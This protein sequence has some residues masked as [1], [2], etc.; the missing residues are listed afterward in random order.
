MNRVVYLW[1]YSSLSYYV[2]LPDKHNVGRVCRKT[3]SVTLVYLQ[4]LVSLFLDFTCD[5]ERY[6]NEK[7]TN[8]HE[9][10]C[11]HIPTIKWST[12]SFVIAFDT[13]KK[14]SSLK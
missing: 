11:P 9:H 1:A 2:L 8:K 5:T 10:P 3:R 6:K 13:K 12:K 14:K 7:Q 4:L